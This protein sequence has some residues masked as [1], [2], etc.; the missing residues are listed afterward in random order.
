MA[1]KYDQEIPESLEYYLKTT[2]MTEEE[3]YETMKRKRL[4]E[5]NHI[6]L[7]VVKKTRKNKERILPLPQQ[8]IEKEEKRKNNE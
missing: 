5:I 6:E 4:P 3:F 8:L 2:G 1:R 7:P